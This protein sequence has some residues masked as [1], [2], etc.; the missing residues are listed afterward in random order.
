MPSRPPAGDLK[1]LIAAGV[2]VL[3]LSIASFLVAPVDSASYA[4]GSSYSPRTDGA[5]AAFLML[6]ASGYGVERSFEPLT[7][8]RR[9]PD[10]T[11][12]ILAAPVEAPSQQDIR[13]LRNFVEAGGIVLTTGRS[14]GVFLPGV[15]VP[16]ARDV[17]PEDLTAVPAAIPS[18][19]TLGVPQI[20]V[21]R[22][23]KPLAAVSNFV[24]VYGDD[25]SPAVVMARFGSG[26]AVWWADSWPLTNEGISTAGHAELLLNVVKH[27]GVREASVTLT[28]SPDGRF[29]LTVADEGSGFDL[30]ELLDRADLATG[31]GLFGLRERVESLGGGVEVRSGPGNGT[32]V[33][34]EVPGTPSAVRRTEPTHIPR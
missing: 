8:L 33:T 28:G 23:S 19:L 15:P 29:R 17:F 6:K 18:P 34:V 3:L 10:R 30:A 5:K 22:A 25:S 4:T 31:L 1:I 26:I 13:V 16:A 2:V 11:V 27:A 14:G 12:L 20:E 9:T 7:A 32:T 21:H 24:T